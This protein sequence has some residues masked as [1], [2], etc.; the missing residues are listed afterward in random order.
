[1][2]PIHFFP[3]ETYTFTAAHYLLE[4]LIYLI[5]F[6]PKTSYAYLG[7][8]PN[9]SVNG[10]GIT[11]TIILTTGWEANNRNVALINDFISALWI[12]LHFDLYRCCL[13]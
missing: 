5:C 11:P 9:L 12:Y 8:Q 10:G 3:C 1:M 6:E 13:G 7:S 2:R 4:I